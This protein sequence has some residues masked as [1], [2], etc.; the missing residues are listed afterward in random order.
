MQSGNAVR[1]YSTRFIYLKEAPSKK[2]P[3][4][5]V[6]KQKKNVQFLSSCN[7]II[8]KLTLFSGELK[9]N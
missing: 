2:I 8:K 4:N 7:K 5:V 9:K 3:I 1:K 6:T